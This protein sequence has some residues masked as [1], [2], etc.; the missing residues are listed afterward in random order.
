MGDR[1]IPV[2]FLKSERRVETPDNAAAPDF[3]TV[4]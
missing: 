1:I 2:F 3:W 4:G